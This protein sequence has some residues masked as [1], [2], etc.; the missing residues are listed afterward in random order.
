MKI[1]Y[2]CNLIPRKPGAFENF[3]IALGRYLHE[4]GDS[5]AVVFAAAPPPQIAAELRDADVSWHVIPRW[6]A[7]GERVRPYAFCLPAVRIVRRE[8]PDIATVHFGNEIPS[9]IAILLSRLLCRRAPRWIWY[10]DQQIA[11]PT[12]LTARFS[13]IKLA[14]LGF[15][16]FIAVYEGGRR[17]LRLRGID[18]DRV[19]VIHN[20]VKEHPQPRRSGLELR[21]ELG[22][23]ANALLVANVNWLVKRKRVDWTIRAF[24]QAAARCARPAVLLI[25]GDGPERPKLEQICAKLGV[26]EQVRFLGHRDDVRDLLSGCDI[27]LHASRA[28]TCTYVVTEAM[29]AGKPVVMTDAGAAREQIEDGVSGFVVAPDDIEGL[30]DRLT[31]LMKDDGLRAQFGKEACRRWERIFRLETSVAKHCRLYR[32]LAESRR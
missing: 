20:A 5:L 13:R 2:F 29:A 14:A 32:R 12:P 6:S 10:Q 4:A 8:Q 23:A 21:H 31:T 24:A 28:E 25:V 27:L 9:L 19:T 7:E 1:L 16:H 18:G 22:I 26:T 11:D 17:S 3:L 30:T 15:A